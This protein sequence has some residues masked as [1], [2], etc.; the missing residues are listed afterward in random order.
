VWALVGVG[1][2]GLAAIL[3]IPGPQFEPYRAPPDPT[4]VLT[5]SP[6]ADG[7]VGAID[8]VSGDST[9]QV[10]PPRLLNLD[11]TLAYLGNAGQQSQEGGTVVLQVR[12]DTTGRPLGMRRLSGTGDVVSR[13]EMV[14]RY[15]RYSPALDESGRPVRVWMPVTITIPAPMTLELNGMARGPIA[16]K[17]IPPGGF[18]IADLEGEPPTFTPLTELPKLL[19]P[20]EV[21]RAV[22]QSPPMSHDWGLPV[23]PHFFLID[24]DGSVR[25][26][27][28]DGFSGNSPEFQTALDIARVYRFSP[29]RHEGKPV[30]VWLRM[31]VALRRA[32]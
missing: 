13:A 25:R 20:E 12:I 31:R 10:T 16:G 28:P 22:A 5:A 1:V 14:A 32:L 19:N 11:E 7:P 9:R 3:A 27:Q 2:A 29:A 23:L 6:D 26:V 21:E 18:T 24:R 4:L 15:Q 8:P 30:P 17:P